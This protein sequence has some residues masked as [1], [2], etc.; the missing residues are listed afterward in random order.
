MNIITYKI[1]SILFLVVCIIFF[2]QSIR[3]GKLPVPT[4]TL[5]GLYHPWRDAV[6]QEYPRGMPYKNFLI[7]DPIR[8]QIPWRKEATER[9]KRGELP[10]LSINNAGS[11]PLLGNIQS[12]TLY[13][14]N[15]IFFLLP[16]E[17]A[18]SVLIVSQVVLAGLF[19]IIYAA[20]V[21]FHPAAALLGAVS[22]SL[23]GFS[24]AW[25]TWGTI[26]H[27]ALWLPLLLFCVDKWREERSYSSL[28]LFCISLCCSFLAGHAQVFLYV[29]TLTAV[30]SFWRSLKPLNET[31]ERSG[32]GYWLGLTGSITVFVVITSIQ[33]LPLLHA[34]QQ[35]TRVGEEMLTQ[36]EG[37]FIPFQH[38]FQLIAP[39]FFGNPATLNYWGSWNYGEMVSYI[40]LIP[41]LCIFPAL[42]WV[43]RKNVFWFFIAIVVF[44]FMTP[45][46]VAYLPYQ[47]NLPLFSTLQ[48]TRLTVLFQ[49]ALI[50]LSVSGL[51]YLLQQRIS[52]PKT[53]GLILLAVLPIVCLWF[54]Y[55][56][57]KEQLF[58]IIPI[59]H[60]DVTRRNIVLPTLLSGVFIC[61]LVLLQIRRILVFSTFMVIFLTSFELIRFG[62]KFTPFTDV[63]YFFPET[64]T[65]QILKQQDLNKRI[66]AVDTKIFPPNTNAF[67]SLPF[68]SHYDPLSSERYERFIAAMERGNPD[69]SKPYGFNRIVAPQRL[70]SPLFPHLSVG[71]ILS[72]TD[73]DA[74]T[75]LYQ[76]GETRLYKL[77]ESLPMVYLVSDVIVSESNQESINTLYRRDFVPGVQAVIE[78]ASIKFEKATTGTIS[79]V[80]HQPERIHVEVTAGGNMLLVIHRVFDPWWRATINGH[81]ST[82]HV[83]N[84]AFMGVVVPSGTHAIELTYG[85]RL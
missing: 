14:F 7:T 41:L 9:L 11:V 76:E 54:C 82:I 59:E 75:L 77:D 43:L 70:D 55:L 63:S 22:W 30:Y 84:G 44:L 66:M 64:E 50:M 5:M 79:V 31:S 6:S 42:V 34:L 72:L 71:Y 56:G 23:G 38:L 40:G 27:T 4:D 58:T 51:D 85:I 53:V 20:H 65:I 36:K 81:Q 62:W 45:T 61:L 47:F 19:F 67:Y 37:W 57:S 21:K 32:M 24:I 17:A 8:Q 46:V 16:F 74:G 3:F 10:L 39:D 26:V 69:I 73:V 49:F 29:F 2:Q 18:W 68:V 13:P 48:P 25:L 33:W 78:S 12:G 52:I 1:V 35:S 28:L 80:D 83:T 60:L 15:I